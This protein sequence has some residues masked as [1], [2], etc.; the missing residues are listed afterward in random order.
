METSI[1]EA[2]QLGYHYILNDDLIIQ[3]VKCNAFCIE[4]S[5]ETLPY[6]SEITKEILCYDCFS[7]LFNF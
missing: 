6:I 1:L 4:E 7:N 5:F 2:I 3:C